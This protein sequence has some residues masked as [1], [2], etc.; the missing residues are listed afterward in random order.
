M[1]AQKW[2][3]VQ[4]HRTSKSRGE[5]GFEPGPSGS[6][7]ELWALPRRIEHENH[8]LGTLPA[9]TGRILNLVGTLGILAASGVSGRMTASPL[10]RRH[11]VHTGLDQRLMDLKNSVY[12]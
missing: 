6:Q 4:G 11:L 8:Q 1:E 12:E 10:G 2:Y 7:P 3:L 5:A 9:Q